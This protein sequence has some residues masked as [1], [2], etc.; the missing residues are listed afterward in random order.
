MSLELIVGLSALFVGI[1]VTSG[2]LASSL[3]A[4][5]APER[6]R[7]DQLA[8]AAGPGVV[9]DAPGL[10]DTPNALAKR[11]AT[12]V[13]KSP[14][15]MTILRRALTSA[16]Y[17]S[18][19][20]AIL[21]S[22]AQTVCPLVFAVVTLGIL[23]FTRGWIFA[24]LAAIVGAMVPGFW[25]T[26]QTKRRQ[27]VIRNGLPDALDLLIVCLEAGSSLDQGIVKASDELEIAYP[28]LAEEL[29]LVTTEIRAGKPR[30]EALKN[31]AARTKVD[32]V[33]ALVAMLVQTDRF[34]TSV[35]QALRTHA[36]T[37]RVKRRQN[38]EERAAKL[39][40]KLV[41]P[42]VF[43]LFPAL[44]VVI[45]GPAAIRIMNVFMKQGVVES[46]R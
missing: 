10:T 32:D 45:L 9:I 42:L 17:R 7:F 18:V 41:F 2:M 3:L 30:L 35:A 31:L 29:R 38:A 25:L 24:I 36:E 13:P 1:A 23:G 28:A 20:A 21:Y 14:K 37:S 5:H 8:A 12:I 11:I 46:F 16:G 22:A 33:R 44:Y 4:R 34:G 26:H 39:S 6:R 19:N 43:F 40:V 15:D 27:K